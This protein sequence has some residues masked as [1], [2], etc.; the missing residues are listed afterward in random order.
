MTISTAVREYLEDHDIDFELMP[1]PYTATSM[2]AAEEAR[3]PGDQLAKSVILEDDEGY[4]MAVVPATHHVELGVLHKQLNRRLGLATEAE[5][6]SMF[7]DCATGAVPPVGQAYG[8]EVIVDDSLEG[9]S[10][11]FFESGDHTDLVHITGKDFQALMADAGH[12][13]FS[14][15]M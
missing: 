14:R 7:T 13:K 6:A 15:H 12:G 1:H 10:D 4:L 2:Q 11:I 9:Y 5:L 3:I 8:Y